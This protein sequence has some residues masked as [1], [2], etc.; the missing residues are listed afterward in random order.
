MS[1]SQ[2]ANARDNSARESRERHQREPVAIDW[3]AAIARL[4][5]ML[6]RLEE[7]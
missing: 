1:E 7:S 6:D 5:A 2:R 3:D 4:K